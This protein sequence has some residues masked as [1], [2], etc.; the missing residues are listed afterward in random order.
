MRELVWSPVTVQPNIKL[1]PVNNFHVNE[2]GA[3]EFNEI[4]EWCEK[5]VAKD[6][7]INWTASG[8]MKKDG[9]RDRYGIRETHSTTELII[10][11]NCRLTRCCFRNAPKSDEEEKKKAIYGA[12]CFKEFRR[13]CETFGVD[14]DDLALTPEEGAAIKKTIPKAKISM[15]P[16]CLNM[17]LRGGN[18]HHLDFNSSFLSGMKEYKPELGPALDYMYEH[19]KDNPLM[20][21]VMVQSWGYMQ[22]LKCAKARWAHLSKAGIE[23]NNKMIELYA[24][25]LRDNGDIILGFNTDGIWYKGPIF[26]D[27]LEGTGLGKWK[28]DHVN[29]QAFRAKSNGAYEYIDEDGKYHPVMRGTTR[30]EQTKPRSE[31]EWGDIYKTE[32]IEFYFDKE[33]RRLCVIGED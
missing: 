6:P 9:Y 15:S 17:E 32:V 20:K 2:S 5:N 30:L 21:N 12:Q 14:L 23:W 13:I 1:A 22:S 31:W 8:G 19:R 18:I 11:Y 26:H 3:E 33:I 24:Q 4:I 7:Q 29:C 16:L 27:E 28:N 25:K 10:Y